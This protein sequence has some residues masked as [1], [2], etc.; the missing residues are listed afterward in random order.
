MSELRDALN[1][2]V[3]ADEAAQ[4]VDTQPA[5]IEPSVTVVD[6]APET[7]VVDTPVTDE[8][9]APEQASTDVASIDAST[10]DTPADAPSDKWSKA[11]SSW[12]GEAKEVWSNLPLNIRQ[13]VTRRERDMNITMQHASQDRKMV[14]EVQNVIAPH[15]DRIN[16]YYGGNPMAAVENMMRIE[17]TL[18]TASAPE[19]A[20]TVA[21]IIKTFKI[22][23]AML[24]TL[25]SGGQLDP[26]DRNALEM[27]RQLDQRFGQIE[28]R[29]QQFAQP[30]QPD[31]APA[32]VNNE[33]EAMRMDTKSYPHFDDL[34]DDMADIIELA[35]R[36]GVSISLKDAYTKASVVAGIAQTPSSA[37]AA[38]AAHAAAQ[39]AKNASA[40]VSG[41]PAGTGK[42]SSDPADL[43]SFISSALESSSGRV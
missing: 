28:Q 3:A 41:S 30:Q 20:Q 43:R 36:R 8:G 23:V 1:N 37:N 19:K 25:L 4:N 9:I 2:A 26:A 5:V 16:Q 12:R 17:K 18:F 35:D 39:K 32:P 29:L 14:G 27:N 11:P 33:I 34:R 22:D 13:E 38:L 7:P 24:D 6:S 15:M 40:S 42:P 31:Y 10:G 21:D